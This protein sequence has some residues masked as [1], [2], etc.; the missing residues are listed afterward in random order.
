MPG[1][2]D[3]VRRQGTHGVRCHRLVAQADDQRRTLSRQQRLQLVVRQFV[4][5]V[6]D[7]YSRDEVV[8]IFVDDFHL[9]IRKFVVNL[10][11]LGYNSLYFISIAAVVLFSGFIVFLAQVAHL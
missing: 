10:F 3:V 5:Y 1:D 11:K 6:I 9:E 7:E 2:E 4:H 8:F